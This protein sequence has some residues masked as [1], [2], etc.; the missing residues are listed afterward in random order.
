MYPKIGD[1][2]L[3]IEVIESRFETN[4]IRVTYG[5]LI[6]VDSYDRWIAKPLKTLILAKP[7]DTYKLYCLERY[8]EEKKFRCTLR[9]AEPVYCFIFLSKEDILFIDA[10]F[11]IS[12]EEKVWKEAYK[13]A[14]SRI[15]EVLKPYLLSSLGRKQI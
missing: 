7:R 1:K 13:L 11:N 12:S 10:I 5:E 14:P 9:I 2:V 6:K 4:S 15:L 3:S 8:F